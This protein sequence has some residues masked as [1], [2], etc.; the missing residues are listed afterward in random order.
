[1]KRYSYISIISTDSY[2]DGL[3]VLNSSLMKTNPSFPFLALL[4]QNISQKTIN[5]LREHSIP[6]KIL[7]KDIYNP[8][9]INRDHRWFLTYCKLHIFNQTEFTKIVFLDADMLILKNIDELFD[10]PHMSATNAGSMLPRKSSWTHINS[11]LMVIEPSSK[12]YLDMISKVGKIEI[13]ESGGTNDRPHAG[14]DQDF[15]NAYYPDWPNKKELHLDHKY[16]IL[17]YYSD[18]YHKL[19]GYSFSGT[20]HPEYASITDII[21]VAM[22]NTREHTFSSPQPI[23]ITENCTGCGVCVPACAFDAIELINQREGESNLAVIK[24]NCISCNACVGVC[25]PKFGAIIASF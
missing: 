3:L 16:N 10:K 1:M 4:T 21:G 8:T 19:F 25:P 6:Y 7:T 2:L 12:L 18:E 9:N 17:H 11:G 22:N 20:D 14:S 5:T 24:D 23:V 13:L 15:L